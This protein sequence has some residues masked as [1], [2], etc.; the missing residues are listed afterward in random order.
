MSN[1]L[2]TEIMKLAMRKL[3]EVCDLIGDPDG[4]HTVI[5][6]ITQAGDPPVGG[7]E[8]EGEG[9]EEELIGFVIADERS[10]RHI[11]SS[12]TGL[13]AKI[14]DLRNSDDGESPLLH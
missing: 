9:D 1:I 14:L 3:L 11:I 8:A 7:G 2:D 10:I 6:A 13:S 12:G 5:G 4:G